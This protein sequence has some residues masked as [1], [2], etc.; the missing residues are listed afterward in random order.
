MNL[1]R[2]TF[3]IIMDVKTLKLEIINRIL[4][5]EDLKLLQTIGRMLDL[6]GF[7]GFPP[8]VSGSRNLSEA[9]KDLQHSINEIFGT[10]NDHE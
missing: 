1:E 6:Q 4:E 8:P 7:S 9:A 3:N 5:T 2:Q 10:S